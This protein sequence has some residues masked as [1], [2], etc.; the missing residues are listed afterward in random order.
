M[1]DSG[2]AMHATKRA[3]VHEELGLSLSLD[4]GLRGLGDC[5]DYLPPFPGPRRSYQSHDF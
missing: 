4:R 3:R 1:P 5:T 2:N